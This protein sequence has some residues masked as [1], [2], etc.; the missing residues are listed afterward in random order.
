M[1]GERCLGNKWCDGVS[2]KENIAEVRERFI[3]QMGL[4]SQ[5][6]GLPRIAGRLM[7]LMVF[8]GRAFSFSELADELQ[9]SR[10]SVSAN[11]RL[12]EER[13]V[14]ERITK[15]GERQDY[16]QL[17]DNPFEALLHQLSNKATR[18]REA[19]GKTV[20]ALPPSQVETR[21]RLCRLQEFYIAIGDLVSD[22]EKRCF[23]R[24]AGRM[25]HTA[26]ETVDR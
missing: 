18:A 1:S 19:I 23:K 3:E 21:K 15:P 13:G 26:L 10:G 5:A 22:V 11:T 4:V 24:P 6:E 9:I 17:A 2:K 20:D 25:Q 8:D 12:L 7:G 14:I 16:F